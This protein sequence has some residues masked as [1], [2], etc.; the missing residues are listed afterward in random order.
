MSWSASVIAVE[1]LELEAKLSSA[2]Q[3]AANSDAEA[4]A[5]EQAHVAIAVAVALA[6]T[7]GSKAVNVSLSGHA[8]PSHE[9]REGYSNDFVSV[10][11]TQASG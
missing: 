9:P 11:V 8:N 1:Q 3:I 5:K 7:T 10:S 6:K 4:E 2:L